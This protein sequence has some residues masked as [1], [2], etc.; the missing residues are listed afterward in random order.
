M[1]GEN[2]A[3][4]I[5]KDYLSTTVEIDEKYCGKNNNYHSCLYNLS[6]LSIIL[7]YYDTK[8]GGGNG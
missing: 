7:V 6:L 1:F 3:P 5:Y 8:V 2:R 4:K